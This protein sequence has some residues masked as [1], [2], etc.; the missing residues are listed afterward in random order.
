MPSNRAVATLCAMTEHPALPLHATRVEDVAARFAT[1]P[2][3]GLTT[4]EATARLQRFGE[5]RRAGRSGPGTR[6]SPDASSPTRSWPYSW[7][8]WSSRPRSA[9]RSRRSRSA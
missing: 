2:A 1:D 3:A 7:S 5:T 8:P 4:A 9:N 6:Q